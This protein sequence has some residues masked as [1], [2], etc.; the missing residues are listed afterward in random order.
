MKTYYA[1]LL[2][3]IT[4]SLG[5]STLS[6]QTDHTS[7]PVD[8]L[9]DSLS[10]VIHAMAATQTPIDS[11]QFFIE[12]FT[13]QSAPAYFSAIEAGIEHYDSINED[14]LVTYL[15]F[16]KSYLLYYSSQYPEA[17]TSFQ[18]VLA[19]YQTLSDN[20][21]I[22]LCYYYIAWIQNDQGNLSQFLE[23]AKS[24][25]RHYKRVNENHNTCNGAM[26]LAV[27][28]FEND[29][30]DQS[31]HYCRKYYHMAKRI[32]DNKH[33]AQA[34]GKLGTFYSYAELTSAKDSTRKYY[35]M[36]WEVSQKDRSGMSILTAG[37]N[38]GELKIEEKEYDLA[39]Y[40]LALA[41]KEAIRTKNHYTIQWI[42]RTMAQTYALAGQYQKAYDAF[43]AHAH[44]KDSIFSEEKNLQVTELEKKYETAEKDK[45]ITLLAQEKELQAQKAR[46]QATV[47]KALL[48][49]LLLICTIAGLVVYLL[50]QRIKNQQQLA[51][52][53]EE[54]RQAQFKHQ[55]SELEMKALRAQM[56]PHFIFNCINSIN[57]MVLSGE[58][59][60]ASRYLTKFAKLI[61][62]MLENSENPVVSLEDELA[63]L[64]SYLQLETLRFKEKLRYQLEVDEQIDQE[65]T[66][67]PSMV[68][69]PFI[70][71]AIW[72]GLM[73]KEGD[74]LIKIFIQGEQG[75]LKCIIEDN[76]VG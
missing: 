54:V 30:L 36:Q 71:N 32:Q 43:R 22:G 45:Q 52:K 75:V 6:A 65:T 31:I 20:E 51:I 67:L 76:G 73:P 56:N 10:E 24:A 19:Q 47:N 8:H 42:E 18:S 68:L 12:G 11:L 50:R 34:L 53:N 44:Y 25:S 55:L 61:R 17:L 70:E 63:L 57:R 3:T 74:G 16:V 1:A 26:A 21:Q 66:R 62:M 48:I 13:N 41:H 14:A 23:Y 59:Q 28:Y 49:G 64:T 37:I 72:H 4:L 29:S 46:Q 15:L 60:C 35:N 69:Q 5:C 39:Q 58:S 40:Y 7:K 27:A 9:A 2:L 33:I 38:M